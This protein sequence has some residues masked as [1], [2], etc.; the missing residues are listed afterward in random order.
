VEGGERLGKEDGGLDLDFVWG[1]GVSSYATAAICCIY[2]A[3]ISIMYGQRTTQDNPRRHT[4]HR[5]A[6]GVNTSLQHR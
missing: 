3:Y 6:T 5:N 2:S 1:P 4:S